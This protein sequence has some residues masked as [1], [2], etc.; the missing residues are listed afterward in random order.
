[1]DNILIVDDAKTDRELLAKVVMKAGY[2]AVFATDGDEVVAAT[3]SL[4]PRLV[5]LD[6]VMARTNGYNACRLL[7]A[8]PETQKIPVVFVTSKNAESDRFWGKKQGADDQLGKPFT[9]ESVLA[10]L[11]RLLG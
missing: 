9:P 8:D 1:M 2:N 7:K 5:F 3:K 11:T 10:V 6:V 4:R